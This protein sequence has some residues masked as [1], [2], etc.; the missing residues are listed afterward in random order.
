MTRSSVTFST[1]PFLSKLLTYK[2]HDVNTANCVNNR[3]FG[4]SKPQESESK[5]NLLL[6]AMGGFCYYSASQ[7]FRPSQASGGAMSRAITT[8]LTISVLT[9]MGCSGG[10]LTTREKGAG[11]G[12]LGGAAAGGIIGAATGHAGAGAA[13]GGVL[14]LGA[15]ALVGDQLQGQENKQKEQQKAIDQQRVEIEKNQALIEELRKRNIEARETSRGVMVN[16]P[17]V[18]FEFDSADLTRDGRS[19]VNQ[20]ADII[21]RDASNRRITVEGHA[22][23]E[24]AAQEAYNQ[25]LSERRANTV[26][27]ALERS[28]VNGRNVS[29]QGL[30]TRAPIATNDTESGRQQNRRVEVVIEN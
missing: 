24:S 20:I 27:D 8:L 22:S 6:A 11:I 12:A 13:I 3:R 7:N 29:A 26:A 1:I 10:S 4:A 15:G 14:G 30:G 18:N 16:L 23:R 5:M 17:S 21:R 9:A 25:R 28:G 19:R 2:V